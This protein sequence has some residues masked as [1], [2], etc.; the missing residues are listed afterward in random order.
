MHVQVRAFAQQQ[1][2]LPSNTLKYCC[3][4]LLLRI[5]PRSTHHSPVGMSVLG[6]DPQLVATMSTCTQQQQE[7]SHHTSPAA[8]LDACL[9]SADLHLSLD[10]GISVQF[11]LVGV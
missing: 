6:N 5:M 7:Q 3:A 1:L 8:R 10:D 4:L 9:R 11:H 2:L